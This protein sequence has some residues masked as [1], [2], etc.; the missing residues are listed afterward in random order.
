MPERT[1]KR[2]EAWKRKLIDLSRRNRLI[3]FRPTRASTV[4]VHGVEPA[5][6][7]VRIG[8]ERA[9]VGFAARPDGAAT[10]DPIPPAETPV[11]TLPTDLTEERLAK[12]LKTI[13]RKAVSIQEE[14]G[15]NVLALG[16]HELSRHPV[17]VLGAE[18]R[19]LR[20]QE[21]PNRAQVGPR[22]RRGRCRAGFLGRRSSGF[23]RLGGRRR[24]RRRGRSVARGGV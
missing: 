12:N 21:P 18:R 15:Y 1:R 24:S 10:G 13:F 19:R 6:L 16:Q 23:R 8:R 22:A 5:E 17:A 7:L 9:S 4:T 3:Q 20:G 2:I 14:H 11:K